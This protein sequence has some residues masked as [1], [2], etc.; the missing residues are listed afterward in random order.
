MTLLWK[1]FKRET[2]EKYRLKPDIISISDLGF[3]LNQHNRIDRIETEEKNQNSTIF[4]ITL[5]LRFLKCMK[6]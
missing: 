6:L 4:Y 2:L 3:Q 5:F 1:Y